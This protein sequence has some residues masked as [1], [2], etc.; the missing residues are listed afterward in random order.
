M[1]RLRGPRTPSEKIVQILPIIS[2]LLFQCS[3]YLD[4]I[5]LH[6]SVFATLNRSFFKFD[7]PICRKRPSPQS[8]VDLL[9]NSST[10]GS[11]LEVAEEAKENRNENDEL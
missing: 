3:H 9:D 2:R 5:W 7:I 8:S 1:P 6:F 10:D 4:D 11:D